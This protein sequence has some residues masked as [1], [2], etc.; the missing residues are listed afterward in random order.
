MSLAF[1]LV[2]LVFAMCVMAAV[3]Y[4]ARGSS[5]R[6]Q[7]LSTLAARHRLHLGSN[8]AWGELDGRSVQVVRELRG[9]GKSR[10][11]WTVVSST[12]FPPLDLGL[13]VKKQGGLSSVW[14]RLS[15]GQDVQIGDAA[16]DEAFLV[17]GD[18][19][20]RVRALLSSSIRELLLAVSSGGNDVYL[21]DHGARIEVRREVLDIHWL[22]AALQTV[23]ERSEERRVGKE[24]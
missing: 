5:G 17:E 9:S 15:G 8:R 21:T 11:I 23:V 20:H 7:V 14:L 1:V 3:A 24:C 18:E 4:Q 6:R 16:F 2:G 12:R 10:E 22:E 13:C 19:P